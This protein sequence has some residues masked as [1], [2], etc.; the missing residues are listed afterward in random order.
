MQNQN[1]ESQLNAVLNQLTFTDVDRFE[2][3]MELLNSLTVA[4]DN[5]Q[6]KYI[7]LYKEHNSGS[8]PPADK[9]YDELMRAVDRLTRQI[10][11]LQNSEA[12]L[13]KKKDI[14]VQLV[15]QQQA[16]AAAAAT[17]PVAAEEPA[18]KMTPFIEDEAA[19]S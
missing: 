6:E 2:K 1:Y 16:V 5:V 14:L 18:K 15:K 7:S 10:V 8:L 13:S 4:H 9:E 19:A 12:G 17:E 11:I 3:Q